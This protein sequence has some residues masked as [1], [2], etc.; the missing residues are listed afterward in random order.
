MTQISEI[1]VTARKREERLQEVPLSIT[2]FDADALK[3]RNIQ[4]VYDVATFTP[5]FSFSRNVVGRRLDAPSIRGQFSP[6]N[7]F[8]SEGNV[9]F[10]VDGVY[11][12]G[13]SSSLTA[14]N[15]ERIEVTAWT[16]GRTVRPRGLLRCRQLRHPAAH[17]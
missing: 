1:V 7:N 4:S 9:A 11:I 10:F 16:T 17:Q 13:T 6:L 14:D 12:S 2:A 5:N 15:V 3:D 8:G